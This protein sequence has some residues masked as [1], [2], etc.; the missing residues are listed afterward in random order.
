MHT[1]G[2][3]CELID[4]QHTTHNPRLFRICLTS[5]SSVEPCESDFYSWQK[6]LLMAW[7]VI[8]LGAMLM[9]SW[10][11]FWIRALTL[12]LS[13]CTGRGEK[14]CEPRAVQEEKRRCDCFGVR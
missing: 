10:R 13:R 3:S 11:C 6:I 8:F 5:A 1:D 9:V 12:A 4:A 7:R 2:L 14:S